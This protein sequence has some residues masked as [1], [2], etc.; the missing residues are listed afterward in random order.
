M[1]D[2][3]TNSRDQL[4]ELRQN[5]DPNDPASRQQMMDEMAKMATDRDA[6]Q[7]KGDPSIDSVL[8]PA[9]KAKWEA[10]K[11]QRAIDARLN[12]LQLTDDQKAKIKALV[13]TAG[14]ALGDAADAKAM[15]DIKGKLVKQI[16]A[17]VLTTDQ[18]ARLVT[19]NVGGGG[20]VA[21]RSRR[22]GRRRRGAGGGGRR[23]GGGGNGGGGGGGG[24]QPRN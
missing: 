3:Q 17:D 12:M 15:S 1:R 24:G 4:N 9:Q 23:G 14:T 7:A 18:A 10:F 8:T 5:A 22:T 19:A 21:R 11:L 13:A 2:F 20:S 6:L 16:V